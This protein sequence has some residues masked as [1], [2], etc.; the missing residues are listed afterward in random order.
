MRDFRQSIVDAA[1]FKCHTDTAPRISIESEGAALGLDMIDLLNRCA[2]IAAQCMNTEDIFLMAGANGYNWFRRSSKTVMMEG[3]FVN[4]LIA[5]REEVSA[6]SM[7]DNMWKCVVT[8]APQTMIAH[9]YIEQ[10]SNKLE[11]LIKLAIGVLGT[12]GD[13]GELF[14]CVGPARMARMVCGVLLHIYGVYDILTDTVT[15]GNVRNA[16]EFQA[17]SSKRAGAVLKE[18]AKHRGSIKELEEAIEIILSDSSCIDLNTIENVCTPRSLK[19][20]LK[21]YLAERRAY[22]ASHGIG[23]GKQIKAVD[24][25]EWFAGSPLT[26]FNEGRVATADILADFIMKLT[27]QKG[28]LGEISSAD[29]FKSIDSM[30]SFVDLKLTAMAIE[31][32]I[33][34]QRMGMA[35]FE[36]NTER[37][38]VSASSGALGTELNKTRQELR[39]AQRENEELREV[40]KSYKKQHQETKRAEHEARSLLAA[41]KETTKKQARRI[42]EFESMAN[43]Q[44]TPTVELGRLNSAMSALIAERQ[45]LRSEL[46]DT[47][48]TIMR[49]R[50]ELDD[51]MARVGASDERVAELV[52]TQGVPG[53]NVN[54]IV[55]A[56]NTAG[57]SVLVVGG[58]HLHG[59]L[60]GF[61]VLGWKFI[62]N[63]AI[64]DSGALGSFDIVAV[65]TKSVSH[66]VSINIK[67]RTFGSAKTVYLNTRSSLKVL[68]GIFN[69][70]YDN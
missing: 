55:D 68:V 15:A 42:A 29:V 49:Q 27:A 52:N 16:V 48:S 44:T 18:I 10:H 46:D 37:K 66:K 30:R 5:R 62:K 63:E 11:A 65:V 58:E 20:Q 69:A 12:A 59:D 7:V 43:S 28:R 40:V 25:E 13:N 51:L 57:K 4:G 23:T 67:Q 61:G 3:K 21:F 24:I 64:P 39:R 9:Y 56:I 41:E 47:Q 54:A 1:R 8:A 34:A 14:Y 22:D 70:I 31:L 38:V 35:A 32:S 36:A 26:E 45:A 33:I 6:K 53:I 60:I 2:P 50:R 19:S 17:G